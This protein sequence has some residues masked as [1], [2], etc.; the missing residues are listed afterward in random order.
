MTGTFVKGRALVVGVSAYQHVNPLPTVV[1]DDARA[2]AAMLSDP[3]H[4]AYDPASVELLLDKDATLARIRE[5]LTRFGTSSKEDESV[6][7]YFSGHGG[8]VGTGAAARTYLVPADAQGGSRPDTMLSDTEFSDLLGKLSARKVT[9]VL[10]AC[11]AGG[12]ATLKGLSSDS[13]IIAPG[14]LEKS[15]STLSSGAGRVVLASSR[16]S[17]TSRILPHASNSLFT[18]HLL[19][20][21]KG[22]GQPNGSEVVR[23][24]NLFEYVSAKVRGDSAERQTPIFKADLSENFAVAMLDGGSAKAAISDD[25]PSNFDWDGLQDVLVA[26]YP[27]GPADQNIWQRAGGDLAAVVLGGSGRADWF[28]ALRLLREGGGGAGISFRGLADAAARDF[29]NNSNLRKLIG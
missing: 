6:F 17:E 27:R 11:H 26:I 12:A 16:S 3:R 2:V 10:D 5:V 23:V 24:F 25:P 1:S 14:Y 13:A 15:L 18:T 22:K 4:C 21:L 8:I 9:V 20:A 7:I 29:P 19:D 28:G